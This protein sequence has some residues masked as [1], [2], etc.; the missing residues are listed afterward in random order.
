MTGFTA[1]YGEPEETL[2]EIPKDSTWHSVGWN[3][4]DDEKDDEENEA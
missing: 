3:P 2:G 1:L 4:P